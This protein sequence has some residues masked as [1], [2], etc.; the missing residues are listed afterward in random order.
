[1]NND[2]RIFALLSLGLLVT[3]LLV[4]FVIAALGRDD[5]A[6]GFG[7]VAGLLALLFGVFS[8]SERIG[9]TVA[10]AVL[11]LLV[12]GGAGMVVFSRIRAQHMRAEMRAEEQRL[13]EGALRQEQRERALERAIAEEERARQR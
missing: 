3:A 9:K 2:K 11:S 13:R 6:V 4:P 10:I 12:V 7:V 5:L 8:W 1:M